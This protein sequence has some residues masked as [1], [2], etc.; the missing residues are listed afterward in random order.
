[1]N[2]FETA[3]AKIRDGIP[4]CAFCEDKMILAH[5]EI[6][7]AGFL[8]KAFMCDRCFSSYVQGDPDDSYLQ[9]YERLAIAFQ[10]IW[11]RSTK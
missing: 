11:K 2:N 7:P 9:F 4:Y 1:M 3:T 10:K 8:L 5:E 6:S